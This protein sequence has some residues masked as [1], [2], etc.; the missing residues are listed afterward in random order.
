M[1][2]CI[3]GLVMVAPLFAMAK[4]YVLVD[5]RHQQNREYIEDES[6]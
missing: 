6:E 1:S 3:L 5:K 2:L 4:I